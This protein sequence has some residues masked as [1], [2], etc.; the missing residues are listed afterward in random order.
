MASAL[1]TH[2]LTGDGEPVVLLNG[3]AMTMAAWEPIAAPLAEH[4][5]VIRCDLRGQLLSPGPAHA[6]LEQHAD[7]VLAL[8][9]ALGVGAAHVIGTSFGAMVGIVLAATH[10]ERV[11]TL[12]A[13]T[14]TA[15]F[16]DEE[17]AAGQPL[18]QACREA[19]HGS[20]D[21]GRIT[22][23]LAPTT[24]SPQFLDTHAAMLAE[25]R[26]R[27][28]AL[29]PQYFAGLLGILELLRGLDLRPLL[30]RITARTLVLGA[31]QDRTFPVERSY[32]LAAAIPHA[33][34]AV[35]ADAPHG[36]FIEQPARVLPILQQ[37]LGR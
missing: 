15:L 17:W 35:I 27:V 32:E 26:A 25:R 11:Q 21:G 3:G 16:Q 10:P 1:L 14:T 8:V 36:V 12:V 31:A 7:D 4:F 37:F 5:R 30:S 9:D 18:V 2:H 20:G 23:L 33:T 13:G 29:P 34:V 28:A 19:A 24:F 22:D 6:S